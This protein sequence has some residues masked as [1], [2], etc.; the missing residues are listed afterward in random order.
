MDFFKTYT[1]KTAQDMSF[2]QVYDLI[3][4]DE[5]LKK[6]TMLHRE[7]LA[8]GHEQVADSVKEKTPQVAVSFRMEGGKAKANCRE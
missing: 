4:N 7:L 6:N 5:E 3:R 8:T 2:E 1:S